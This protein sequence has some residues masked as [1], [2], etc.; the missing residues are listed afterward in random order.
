MSASVTIAVPSTDGTITP[1]YIFFR[2]RMPASDATKSMRPTSRHTISVTQF[3][4]V[5]IMP[6]MIGILRINSTTN[7]TTSKTKFTT[8]QTTRATHL[9]IVTTPQVT[10]LPTTHASQHNH[11]LQQRHHQLQSCSTHV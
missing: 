11:L 10:T 7:A 5:L 2:G 1:K 8:S 4:I 9:P 6:P 3:R